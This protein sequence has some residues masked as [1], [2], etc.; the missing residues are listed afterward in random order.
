M[1]L[2]WIRLDT[3]IFD[4][5]KFLGLFADGGHRAVV[6]HLAAMCYAGKHG[7]DGFIPRQALLRIE[8]RPADVARLV[9]AQLWTEG[10]GGWDVNGWD[11]YQISDDD[12]RERKERAK[13]AA[14]VR[15]S[16]QQVGKLKAVE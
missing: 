4:H 11:E 14:A 8:G 9:A 13:H 3:S 15:W 16:K 12:A 1:G 6:V 10:A 7:T 2:P 5:P